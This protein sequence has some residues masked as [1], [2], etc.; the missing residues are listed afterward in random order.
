MPFNRSAAEGGIRLLKV[1][2]MQG[3]TWLAIVRRRVEFNQRYGKQIAFKHSGLPQFV[4][5]PQD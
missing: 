3:S 2:T 1:I 4:V 5:Q